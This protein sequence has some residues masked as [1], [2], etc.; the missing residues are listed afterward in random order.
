MTDKFPSPQELPTSRSDIV[1][2]GGK[3]LRYLQH[4]T[5]TDVPYGSWSCRNVRAGECD[6][7]DISQILAW[8]IRDRVSRL[9]PALHFRF[10]PK[11]DSPEDL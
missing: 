11:P 10:A 9:C 7:T 3:E 1:A 4:T 6:R 2:V 5:Q 8:V